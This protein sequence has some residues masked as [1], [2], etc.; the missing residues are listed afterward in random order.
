[1]TLLFIDHFDKFHFFWYRWIHVLSTGEHA[2]DQESLFD[3]V[4]S[5][6]LLTEW[7]AFSGSSIDPV[8]SGP[9][10]PISFSQKIKNLT[11]SFQGFCPGNKS[12]FYSHYHG[13][14]PKTCASRG[15]RRSAR[16]SFPG[17]STV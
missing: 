16:V 13:H 3:Q 1:R 4:C 14:Q 11:P 6:V 7:S 17:H 15:D 12:P 2:L 10:T 9:V 8:G 5:I